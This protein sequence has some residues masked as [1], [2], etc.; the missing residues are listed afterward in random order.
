MPRCCPNSR[1]DQ[2]VTPNFFGSVAA[3]IAEWSNSRGRPDR[4][5]SS[6]PFRPRSMYRLRYWITVVGEAPTLEA[7]C[8]FGS[9]SAASTR[10][11]PAWPA[12]ADR[13]RPQPGLQLLTVTITED[14]GWGR[15]I[16]HAASISN[17]QEFRN[18][19][20][21]PL[22]GRL[23]RARPSFM[24]AYRAPARRS[25]LAMMRWSRIRMGRACTDGPSVGGMASDRRRRWAAWGTMHIVRQVVPRRV[26]RGGGLGSA[27][28]PTPR[29]CRSRTRRWALGLVLVTL[30][31]PRR[32][33]QHGWRLVRGCRWFGPLT[34]EQA[35][36]REARRRVGGHGN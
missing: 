29:P 16:R 15:T 34:V 9:P 12:S 26:P 18:F 22:A 24:R 30:A 3:T 20:H 13:A 5:L 35:E 36:P 14:Q 2:C 7:I 25:S 1:V 21:E 6:R 32:E 33:G 19:Q 8:R 27:W 11:E 28:S 31:A 23:V 4:S 10:S 17:H